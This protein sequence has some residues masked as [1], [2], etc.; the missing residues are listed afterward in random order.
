MSKKTELKR[1][2]LNEAGDEF[3]LDPKTIK[4]RLAAASIEP[5]EDGA[6]STQ[7]ICA[8]VYGDLHGQKLRLVRAQA[9][10]IEVDTAEKEGRLVDA[11]EFLRIGQQTMQAMVQTI[12][13]A[14]GLE[15]EDKE[16]LCQH[17]REM[18]ERMA[19]SSC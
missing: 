17:I 8:A 15:H 12:L 9:R 7:Q 10:R 14:P 2:G 6:F 13:A 5:G 16:K 4:K 3:G 19:K 18:G 11:A 1:W